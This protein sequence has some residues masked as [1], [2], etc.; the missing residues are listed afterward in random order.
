M[1]TQTNKTT[2]YPEYNADVH[3]YNGCDIE[4]KKELYTKPV[5]DWTFEAILKEA[6]TKGCNVIVKNGKTEDATWYLKKLD[7][8]TEKSMQEIKEKERKCLPSYKDRTVF[9]IAYRNN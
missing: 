8:P 2:Y 5:K 6:V 4:L 3:E 9:Y 7:K 1:E